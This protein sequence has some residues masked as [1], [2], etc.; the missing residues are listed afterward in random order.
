MYEVRENFLLQKLVLA[1]NKINKSVNTY[2]QLVFFISQK[3][4]TIARCK[5]NIIAI[6]SI[7]NGAVSIKKPKWK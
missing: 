3:G 5:Y 7:W 4:E 1:K 2:P 6:I